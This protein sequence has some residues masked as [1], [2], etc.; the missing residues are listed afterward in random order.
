MEIIINFFK[1]TKQVI[2]DEHPLFIATVL[3]TIAIICW[4]KYKPDDFGILVQIFI[5][6]AILWYSLETRIVKQSTIAQNDIIKRP[7]IDLYFRPPKEGIDHKYYFA[8]RNIGKGVAYN[9]EVNP[10]FTGKYEYRFYIKQANSILAPNGDEKALSLVSYER[11]GGMSMLDI[12][13][14]II[15]INKPDE[16]FTIFLIKYKNIENKLFYS[17]F[18]FYNKI[19][20]HSIG[21]SDEGEPQIEFIENNEGEINYKNAYIICKNI[22]LKDSVFFV[23]RTQKGKK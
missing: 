17:L 10:I 18:K 22:K 12:N 6:F 14:F 13:N 5:F 23:E 16:L 1:K 20:L 15:D 8:L 9:V 11:G 3:T 4:H 21:K 19:P 7:V 2:I